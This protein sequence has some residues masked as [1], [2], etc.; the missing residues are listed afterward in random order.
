MIEYKFSKDGVKAMCHDTYLECLEKLADDTI[1]E[2]HIEVKM[3]NQ[4][5]KIPMYADCLEIITAA[6][7]ECEEVLTED[8]TEILKED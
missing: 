8:L 6:L 3:G 2:M 1:D 5:I 4:F 7:K